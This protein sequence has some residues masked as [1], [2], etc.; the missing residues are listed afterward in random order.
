MLSRLGSCLDVDRL[1]G[2]IRCRGA[3]C[4]VPSSPVKVKLRLVNRC[5]NPA[6]G[7][8]MRVCPYTACLFNITQREL[9]TTPMAFHASSYSSCC[10][11]CTNSFHFYSRLLFS[12]V[13]LVCFLFFVLVLFWSSRI[14]IFSCSKSRNKFQGTYLNSACA[15]FSTH[16][17][18]TLHISDFVINL[19]S[20]F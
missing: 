2:C 17:L 9:G 12:K 16:I 6:E 14:G 3:T 5:H 4:S 13:F 15:L 20:E 11:K 1:D 19:H 18:C 7:R 10:Y 8:N